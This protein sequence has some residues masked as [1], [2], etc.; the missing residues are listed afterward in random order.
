MEPI[1]TSIRVAIDRSSADYRIRFAVAYGALFI[2]M[3]G[4]A[5]RYSIGWLGWGIALTLLL[6]STVVLFFRSNWR[7]TFRQMPWPL[8]S[9]L[10]L[11]LVGTIWSNYPTVTLGAAIVQIATTSFALFLATAF[12]WRELLRLFANTL[13]TILFAS[14][15]FELFAAVIVRGPIEPFFPNYDGDQPPAV[16][17][18]W[19]QGNIFS[20]DRIQGIVG[21]SN[22]L[23]YMAMIAVVVFA[24]ERAANTTSRLI[25]ILSF[26]AALPML[27]LSRSAS[28]GFAMAA[29]AAAAVVS[30]AVEGKE[31]DV[32]HRYYRVAWLIIGTGA[33]LVLTYRA[34]IFTL[35]GKSPDMTGRTKIWKIVLDLI[36]ERPLQGWGWT[37]YWVPWVEPYQGLVVINNVPYF[38]AHNAFLD[39]WLQLGAIGL[40]LFVLLV[41][42][43]F[44]R[45][46][47]LAVRHTNPLYL[48]PIL[49]FVGIVTQNLTESRI[50]V[51][52]GWVILVLFAVKV[53]DPDNYLEPR[54]K[55]PKLTR[56]KR[57]AK[58]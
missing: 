22:M 14:V 32:R 51:E 17:F 52:I 16:A 6:A 38:Q 58:R 41:G 18:F 54:G 20:D 27:I 15:I 1:T 48:W 8:T 53:R 50:L 42:I 35:L 11:M 12:D 46:W 24:I 9:L 36:D 45:V 19:T 25:T 28:I 39:V 49:V 34:T 21:N 43:T 30:I 10:A 44:V 4:D 37:S 2:L 26:S 57:L 31:R 40:G 56:I 13:R 23:A 29:V 3:G 47:R 33:L 5:I 55:S 7:T